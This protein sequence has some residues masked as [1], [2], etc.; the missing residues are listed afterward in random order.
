MPVPEGK[1]LE[2]ENKAAGGRGQAAPTRELLS[3][4]FLTQVALKE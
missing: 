2:S 4:A 3:W 1:P